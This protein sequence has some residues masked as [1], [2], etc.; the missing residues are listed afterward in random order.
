MID[1]K[2]RAYIELHISVVLYGF[3]AILG[4]LI[5]IS[6]LS[7]VW[8]RVLITSL[9]F[10]L[11]LRNISF[12][13]CFSRAQI[14]SY[15]FIGF[16]IAA[17]WVCFYSSIKL[18][19]ASIALACMGTISIF[20]A[21]L[22]PYIMKHRFQAAEIL[23]GLFVIPGIYLI[24]QATDVSMHNGIW[25]GL[26]ASAL[27]AWFSTLN[28]K[29][30]MKGKE[31]EISCLELSSATLTCSIVLLVLYVNGSFTNFW[32]QE[33]DWIYLLIL[34]LFCTT[35]AFLLSLR[36]LN[37]I[38]TFSSNLIFNLE[39]LYGILLAIIILKE[40]QDLNTSFYIGV[41]IILSSVFIFPLI[42]KSK[43]Y[44]TNQ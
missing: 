13:R 10:L 5:S 27:V 26:I 8:W 4:D 9:S 16:L 39:P 15:L 2:L 35:L 17:H 38:S 14:R 42:S 1:N 37:Y 29:H 7:L 32:P 3:T 31:I 19:K 34:S 11:I 24:A 18:A 6:A 40:H 21:L 20:T 44:D 25:V 23:T 43:S 36:P 33:N 22:E 12:I 28:K 41:G 30:I